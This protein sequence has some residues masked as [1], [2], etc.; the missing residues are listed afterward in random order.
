MKNFKASWAAIL[1][2]AI[3]VTLVSCHNEKQ[4][5]EYERQQY[6]N[7]IN[8]PAFEEVFEQATTNFDNLELDPIIVPEGL[9]LEEE[10]EEEITEET[11]F[12]K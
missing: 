6:L 5:K 10:V 9:D 12:H 1:G 7:S 11:G 3:G 4:T 2:I 8:V